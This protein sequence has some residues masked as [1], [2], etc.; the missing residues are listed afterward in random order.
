MIKEKS[1]IYLSFSP[2]LLIE[3]LKNRLFK[4]KYN[5]EKFY[6]IYLLT[7]KKKR[8]FINV[9]N[10]LKDKD[11]VYISYYIVSLAYRYKRL[12]IDKSKRAFYSLPFCEILDGNISYLVSI[13]DLITKRYD[14]SESKVEVYI[15]RLQDKYVN[16]FLKRYLKKNY[17]IDVKFVLLGRIIKPKK[18]IICIYQYRK[19]LSIF[20]IFNQIPLKKRRDFDRFKRKKI[21]EVTSF[22]LSKKSYR[23]PLN[24]RNLG[25]KVCSIDFNTICSFGLNKYESLLFFLHKNIK[26]I[27]GLDMKEIYKIIKHQLLIDYLQININKLYLNNILLLLNKINIKYL[28]CSH[29]SPILEDLIYKAC[30]LSEVKSIACDFSLRYPYKSSF[31]KEITLTSNPDTNIVNSTFTR[32]IFKRANQVHVNSGNRLEVINC[33]CLL[34]EYARKKTSDLSNIKNTNKNIFFSIFD[35]NYGEN[36]GLSHAFAEELACILSKY[37]NRFSC[38]VHSKT[39]RL[40]LENCL[41]KK[42][43]KNYRALKGDFSLAN[44]SNLIISIGFQGSAIKASFAFQKPIIFFANHKSYFEDMIFSNKEIYNQQ[45]I[46]VFKK[47]IFCKDNIDNLLKKIN[48]PDDLNEI[49]NLTNQFL[50]LVGISKNKQTVL[51]YLESLKF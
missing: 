16:I 3:I 31:K 38:I 40:Y 50:E 9:K 27:I 18:Q 24:N 28:F 34:I 49:Q 10:K 20:S 6:N 12:K 1:K 46:D 35:N 8:N 48:N 33:S 32:E 47:L 2:I 25:E 39:N 41:C 17:N 19:I 13:I 36:Y 45:T 42:K 44:E 14:L 30:R 21:L 5:L 26:I 29:R 15:D 22:E 7:N 11:R 37:R 4:R 51:S 23:I 43:I